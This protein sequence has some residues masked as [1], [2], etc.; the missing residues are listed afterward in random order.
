MGILTLPKVKQLEPS[1]TLP[2]E[3]KGERD[4]KNDG[5]AEASI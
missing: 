1:S 2:K 4:I 5:V 3:N